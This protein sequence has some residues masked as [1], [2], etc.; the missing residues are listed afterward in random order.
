MKI[1]KYQ[2]K[3]FLPWSWIGRI[4]IVKMT[5]LLKAIY[6]F[7]SRPIKIPMSFFTEVE[8]LTLKF[9][10]KHQRPRIPKEILTK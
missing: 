9:I 1:I 3:K 8:K 10:W 7:K 5:M 2:R 6:R 4:N